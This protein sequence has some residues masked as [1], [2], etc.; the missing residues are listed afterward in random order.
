MTNRDKAARILAVLA[1]IHRPI[2]FKNIEDIEY[3]CSEKELDFYYFW[4]VMGGKENGHE[5]R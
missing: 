4:I 5:T 1:R 2:V 3:G